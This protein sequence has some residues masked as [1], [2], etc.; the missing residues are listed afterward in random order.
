MSTQDLLDRV[1]VLQARDKV[2]SDELTVLKAEV[3][4]RMKIGDY[5]DFTATDG[6]DVRV[7]V[8]SGGTKYIYDVQ[9]YRDALPDDVFDEITSTTIDDDKLYQA[10]SANRIPKHLLQAPATIEKKG[11]ARVVITRTRRATAD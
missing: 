1:A 7:S 9:A 8:Q 11:T 4:R 5:A 2:I 6:R 3:R 10:I